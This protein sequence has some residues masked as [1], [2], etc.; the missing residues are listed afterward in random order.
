MRYR[1]AG[2][3]PCAGRGRN[4]AKSRPRYP[5]PG[6]LP[7]QV[8]VDTHA[9]PYIPGGLENPTRAMGQAEP[10][11]DHQEAKT[12]PAEMVSKGFCEIVI[13]ALAGV[14]SQTVVF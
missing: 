11:R 6:E 10:H 1:T 5:S 7:R 4:P 14:T 3:G 13:S 12:G 2:N 9:R 8:R